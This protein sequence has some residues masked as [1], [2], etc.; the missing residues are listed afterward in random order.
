LGQKG[1]RPIAHD[2]SQPIGQSPRLSQFENVIL[3]RSG[4]SNTPTMCR[5]P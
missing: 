3:W 4:G 5:L 1:A 2:F